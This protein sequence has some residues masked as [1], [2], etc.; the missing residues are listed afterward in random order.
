MTIHA[1]LNEQNIDRAKKLL[2]ISLYGLL[3]TIGIHKGVKTTLYTSGILGALLLGYTLY[4]SHVSSIPKY[5]AL[6]IAFFLY[7]LISPGTF[8][9][10]ARLAGRFACA[11]F[12]GCALFYFFQKDLK[13][14]LLSQTAAF[15]IT[16]LLGA[17]YAALFAPEMFSSRLELTYGN[18]HR[19]AT[20]GA[21]ALILFTTFFD[22]FSSKKRPLL[23]GIAIFV[24][25]TIFLTVSRSTFLGLIFA[26]TGYIL[27]YRTKNIFKIISIT[28]LIGAILS[29][30]CFT[31]L[32]PKQKLRIT[33]PITTPLN[34]HTIRQRMAIW[35]TAIEGIKEAPIVGHALRGFSDFD[36]NYKTKH[37]DEMMKKNLLV[38][39]KR[40][41]HP[42]SIYLGSVFGW[43]ILGTILFIL[44]FAPALKHSSGRV[45]LFLILMTCFNLGYG[46]T[47]LRITSDDGAFFVFFPLGVAYGS[48]LLTHCTK[49]NTSEQLNA[50]PSI[51]I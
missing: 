26:G 21:F 34:D 50:T 17:S 38:E 27:F 24:A 13:K 51:T 43:G 45:R 2:L 36:S 3:I 19:L 22:T 48:I 31:M 16:L 42:H 12:A 47:E 44:A 9:I 10:D 35:Y 40:W 5:F 11:F 8:F 25:T 39:E 28:I 33:A 46:V 37:Y 15:I 30:L 20:N 23:Y 49:G 32:S 4:K 7:V 14:V 1:L 6:P 29:T 18:P 41:S